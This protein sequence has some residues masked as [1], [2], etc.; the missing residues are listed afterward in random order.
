MNRRNFLAASLASAAAGAAAPLALA[1]DAAP[2][3][4]EYYELRRYHLLTPQRKLAD[5]YFQNA[6][7]PGLNRLGIQTVGVFNVSVGAESPS[8]YVLIPS[9]S[10]ETLAN[11]G[12]RLAQ[13]AEFAKAASDFLN[14]P[15]KSPAYVRVESSLLSAFSGHPKLTVPAATAEKSPRMFEMRTYESAT[16][17]DHRAKIAE[18]NEGEIPIFIKAGFSPVFF[19]D[20]LIGPRMPQLTYMIGFAN[21]TERDKAWDSFRAAPETKALFGQPKFTFEDLVTNTDNQILTPAAYSQV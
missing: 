4:R 13:D 21:L 18:F 12:S 11:A 1:Q 10:L 8:A 17:Q 5:S 2:A 3:A 16:D 7:V 20:T 9:T 6:L 14:A 15:E 19:G